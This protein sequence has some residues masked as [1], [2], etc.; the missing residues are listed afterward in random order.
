MATSA[1]G[2]QAKF[3]VIIPDE[4]EKGGEGNID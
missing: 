3:A 4:L 1:A 2:D